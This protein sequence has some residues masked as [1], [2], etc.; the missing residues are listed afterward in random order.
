MRQKFLQARDAA[1]AA[2]FEAVCAIKKATR[3]TPIPPTTRQ[4]A[5][6]TR[7][8]EMTATLLAE[9]RARPLPEEWRGNPGADN[10]EDAVGMRPEFKGK[11]H[12]EIEATWDVFRYR[13]MQH[14]PDRN[15]V[16]Q[17]DLDRSESW[18][19]AAVDVFLRCKGTGLRFE[20]LTDLEKKRVKNYF[21]LANQFGDILEQ[22]QASRWLSAEA[23]GDAVIVEQVLQEKVNA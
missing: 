21:E 10:P 23:T 6:T 15:S 19:E 4:E 12:E 3:G 17:P 7:L 8:Q 11:T 9:Y 1:Y 5:S 18:K 13:C 20:D 2:Y 14:H 22:V 16:G